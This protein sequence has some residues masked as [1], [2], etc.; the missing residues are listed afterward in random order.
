MC[1]TRI[2]SYNRII[3][4]PRELMLVYDCGYSTLFDS[5]MVYILN[6]MNC[7]IFNAVF[8]KTG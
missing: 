8:R 5:F 4:V 2:L 6:I 7:Y 1:N 3:D